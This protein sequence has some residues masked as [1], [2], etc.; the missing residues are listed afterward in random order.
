MSG[1]VCKYRVQ[2]YFVT[3]HIYDQCTTEK[4]N[5]RPIE[6]IS[7]DKIR[8]MVATLNRLRQQN[9]FVFHWF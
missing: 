2:R 3:F 1:C 4:K 7:R 9:A 8:A 5:L 6:F